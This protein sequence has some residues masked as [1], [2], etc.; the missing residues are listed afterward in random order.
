MESKGMIGADIEEKA[1][2]LRSKI[3]RIR[4]NMEWLHSK[5]Q[6]NELASSQIKNA[7]ASTVFLPSAIRANN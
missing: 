5:L 3:Q 4:E 7:P 1:E 6:P 2:E